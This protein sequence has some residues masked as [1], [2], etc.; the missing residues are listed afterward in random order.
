MS[1]ESCKNCSNRRQFKN[2]LGDNL[3]YHTEANLFYLDAS[4][5]SIGIGTSAPNSGRLHVTHSSGTIGYFESTQ[6]AANVANIVA[7]S[8]DVN[9][10]ANLIL[11]INSGTSAQG[12][13]R[14]NGNN[15]IDFHNGAS[16]TVKAR[17]TSAG[18]LLV[19][20]TLTSNN[21]A[22]QGFIAHGSTAGESGI[23]SVD[24]TSMAAGVG[25]EISFYGKTSGSGY[26]YLGHIR[27]I[28]ENGTDT[29]TACALTFHTRP[30]LTA[31]QERVRITSDGLIGVGTATPAAV[32]HLH[33]LDNPSVNINSTQ[34]AQNNNIKINFGI[35]Q[36]ASTNGNTG[37]RIQMVIP[38]AGGAMNGDLRFYT[39]HG[40]S[41]IE[42]VRITES[43][44]PTLLI[45]QTTAGADANGWTLRGAINTSSVRF[46]STDVRTMFFMSSYH[47][48]GSADTKFAFHTNGTMNAT[49]TTIQAFSSERRTKKNIVA[50]NLE[51]AWNTLRDTPFYTFNYKNEI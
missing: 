7:N 24:T 38:N 36:Q 22:I 19:G 23:T 45:G 3:L 42:K 17:I 47:S 9:S 50:L 13:I 51:K 6:T 12:I 33:L 28:K 30:T 15:S 26:N 37:A 48:T 39:N 44:V 29:N 27:G 43:S 14:L 11:Q 32:V 21:G 1:K 35:G 8:T 16:P 41:L 34:H 4:T 10:S 2:G 40:D 49:N 20:S 18:L 46:T 25:G 5:N 31:P